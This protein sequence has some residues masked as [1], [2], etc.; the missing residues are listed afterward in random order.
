MSKQDARK[1]TIIEELL[2]DRFN[3]NQAAE[4][5]G[6]RRQ[7]EQRR[8][9]QERQAEEA[10]QQRIIEGLAG[11]ILAR[12]QKVVPA[13]EQMDYVQAA[14]THLACLKLDA[15]AQRIEMEGLARLLRTLR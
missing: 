6:H 10:R 4:L 2:A 14:A 12:D 8:I 7:A 5:L 9:E 15:E 1:V 13:D 11:A 3:N